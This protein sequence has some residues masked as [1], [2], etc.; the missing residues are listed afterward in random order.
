MPFIDLKSQYKSIQSQLNEAIQGVLNHGQYIMGPEVLELERKLA[1]NTGSEYCVS[2]SS[3]TDAL[4]MY[5]IAKGI[6]QGDAVFT[7]SFTFIATAEVIQ[8]LGATPIFVDIRE[9]TFNIDHNL[10]KKSVQDCLS[11][12]KLQPKGIIP[13]DLFGL[14]AEYDSIEMIGDEF[15]LFIL[16]DAAQ[17]FGGSIQDKKSGTFGD[18]SATSFF[19]AKPLGCYGDGGAVFT[20]DEDL[21]ENLIS[22]REHG[23]GI[24]K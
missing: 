23:K 9:D 1:L 18:A 12:G 3:G 14:L 10:L 7:S 15:N 21:I 6:G 11:I 8:L 17:S 4:L 13:V 22:I 16:E 2:C 24:S 5:L 19:P 20:D